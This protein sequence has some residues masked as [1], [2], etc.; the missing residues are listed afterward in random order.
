MKKLADLLDEATLHFNP[1]LNKDLWDGERLKSDVRTSLLNFAEAWRRFAKIP[2]DAVLDVLMVGGNASYFYNE[3]SDVDVHLLLDRQSLGFGPMTDEYLKDKKA[4]WTQKYDVR[5]K[6]YQ[7]EP[8]AQDVSETPPVG[9][10]V[11][12]LKRNEWVQKPAVSDYDPEKDEVLKAKVSRWTDT[13]D[14]LV[15]AGASPEEFGVLKNKLADMRSGSI[16][17]G[18]ELSRGNLVFKSLRLAGVLDRMSDY[19]KRREAQ[20]ISLS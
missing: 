15:K 9:Q 17:K 4:L 11:Y 19:V 14:G 5:V 8:Y 2:E 1:T 6:G 20:D 13:I 3:S 16:R 7:V 18:G 12:S 10:G